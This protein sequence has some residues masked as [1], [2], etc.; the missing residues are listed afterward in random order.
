MNR[1]LLLLTFLGYCTWLQAQTDK[2]CAFSLSGSVID[3]HDR[4]SLE[5]ATIFL[6]EVN[7][8]V[9]ADSTGFYSINKLC[10][11]RY[12][13]V[14]SH[15]SCQPDTLSLLIDKNTRQDL[16]LE[17]HAEALGQITIVGRGLAVQNS[18]RERTIGLNT[19]ERYSQRNLGDVLKELP[20]VSSLNTGNNIVKPV[21]QGLYGSRIITVNH[22]VRMQDMEWGDEH[23]AMIDVNTAGQIKL[24]SGG[25]ALRYGGDALA[26]VILVEQPEVPQDTITGRTLLSGA[27][28]GLGG[29]ITSEIN[30]SGKRGWFVKLQGT[31]RRFGDYRAPDYQLTNTGVF[32]KGASFS[33]GRH[34]SK[35]R[36]DAYY[37]IYDKDVAILAAS[38]VGNIGDLVNAINSGQPQII[39]DFSYEIGLP[40]QEVTH[41]MATLRLQRH[42]AM[43]SFQF[44]YD[45]QQNHRFE[46]DKRV[47]EDR[48][49][50]AIDLK[51]S[52]HSVTGYLSFNQD[53][54]LPMETGLMYR[55]QNNFANPATGI[56]RLIPDYDKYEIG[57]YLNGSYQLSD[58]VALDGGLRFDFSRIDALKFYRKSRWEE[59]GYQEDFPD[60]VVREYPT[61]LLTNP[62]FDYNNFSY[63]AGMIY[64]WEQ[65][66]LRFNY[67]FVQ[68][69]PNPA[70][71]FS[72]G[73]HQGAA[74]IELGD[75][76]IE[77]EA[78]HKLSFNWVGRKGMWDWNLAP[79]FNL[80]RDFVVLEPTGVEYTIRGSFPVWEY[81]QIDANIAGI[82]GE[83]TANW[84]D[85]WQSNHSAMYIYGQDTEGDR[86][87]INMP[88]PQ[89]RNSVSFIRNSWKSLRITLESIYTFKQHRYPNNNFMVFV[90]E[91][92]SFQELD[93]SSPPGGY[94]LLNLYASMEFE[95]FKTATV[96]LGISLVNMT[97]T[98]YRDYLN[99]LRYFADET[100]RSFEFNMTFN[101]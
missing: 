100:G 94:H 13:V 74:R 21:I 66:E 72:D 98:R 44:Q 26:G 10:E 19:I 36:F 51:L 61:Q 86:P 7:R 5:F 40:K 83:L 65:N 35:G 28:N 20:G 71:L 49:Q 15:V 57:V 75:L 48:N 60:I 11:G 101:Y 90:P 30:I 25:S 58:R 9:V 95:I 70:E 96:D 39:E 32:D 45:F 64:H 56:R 14:V 29:N 38:H 55:Y 85:N 54:D 53:R 8:G 43:G 50:P 23:G 77:Q 41:Q 93:I 92:D 31:L 84:D 37:S 91:T 78:S 4:S 99:R 27:S 47:G 79:Y 46:F 89:T 33:A 82:D 73:L 3:E 16:Y 76:R 87:L 88:A 2:N 80:V 18:D 22:G 97:N 42:T 69:A 81:H 52:T 1:Y 63:T 12:T 34:T 24:I 59:R 68:R 62:K 17:H 67:A 6:I